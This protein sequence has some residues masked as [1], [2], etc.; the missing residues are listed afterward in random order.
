LLATLVRR[1]P[2]AAGTN[3]TRLATLK[4]IAELA[5]A[6]LHAGDAA[7]AAD[8][9]AALRQAMETAPPPAGAS[10]DPADG[11]AVRL[12]KGLLLWN[13]T[14]SYVKQELTKLEAAIIA[15]SA[16]EADAD[17]IK[18]RVGEV[19]DAIL[20][21]L[22]DRLTDKL[23]ELRGTTDLAEKRAISEDARQ[24]V[25][26]YQQFIAEDDL[27]KDIDDNGVL[28]LDIRPRLT[29]VLHAVLQIV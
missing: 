25:A 4:K 2:E 23:N 21:T 26:S 13:G 12:A 19:S 20:D 16:N 15:Q 28:P 22:D 6:R 8:A 11:A 18:Q 24:I 9:I 3:P 14:R 1:I 5:G 7:G 29:T 10:G 17:E 27:M